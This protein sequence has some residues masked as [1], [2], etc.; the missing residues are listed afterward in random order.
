MAGHKRP[1]VWSPAA[2]TDLEEIWSYHVA[3]AGHNTA[4]NVIREIGEA[5]RLLEG[6]PFGGRA[7]DEVRPGLRSVAVSPFVI[8]YRVKDSSPEIARVLDGR[9]DLD[10]IF[11]A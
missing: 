10:D 4:E 3:V 11:R 9:R 5:V 2:R 1:V 8:F 6:H 7:R